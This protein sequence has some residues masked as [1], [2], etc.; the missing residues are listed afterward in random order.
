ME[1]ELNFDF[2]ETQV[3]VGSQA[4]NLAGDP[5]GR[6]DYLKTT[7]ISAVLTG[8]PSVGKAISDSIIRGPGVQYNRFAEWAK[9]SGYND[10]VGNNVGLLLSKPPL[11]AEAFDAIVPSSG[12]IEHRLLYEKIDSIN[13]SWLARQ[14][15]NDNYPDKFTDDYK[16]TYEMLD[17]V[18]TGDLIITFSDLTEVTFTPSI[19]V[20]DPANKQYLYIDYQ[21]RDLTPLTPP[22]TPDWTET[23]VEDDIPSTTGYT[24]GYVDDI[25][26]LEIDP[27]GEVAT[28]TEYL[29]IFPD[30]TDYSTM[31]PDETAYSSTTYS[32]NFNSKVGTFSK[33]TYPPSTENIGYIERDFTLH[34]EYL[35]RIDAVVTPVTTDTTVIK[36][37]LGVDYTVNK[38]VVTTTT[39]R[40]VVPTYR[41]RETY[42]DTQAAN[43]ESPK[44]AIYLMG[45]DVGIDTLIGSTEEI[46][47]DY[48]P[49]IPVRR[50]NVF[51]TEANYPDQYDWNKRAARHAFGKNILADLIENMSTSPQLSELDHAWI[52]FGVSLGTKQTEGKEYIYQFFKTLVGNSVGV[53]GVDYQLEW[54]A[55]IAA[56]D[57]YVV[58]RNN[59][60]ENS[61]NPPPVIPA[62][63]AAPIHT[64]GMRTESGNSNFWIY[65][66]TITAAGGGRTIGTGFHPSSEN[67]VGNTWIRLNGALV[68]EMPTVE[69]DFFINISI[70]YPSRSTDIISIGKQLTDN[71]WEEYEFWDMD[72]KSV[73]DGGHAI[74]TS[75]SEAVLTGGENFPFIIPM[76]DAIFKSMPLVSRNQLALESAFLV[77][78]FYKT[79]RVDWYNTE[80]FQFIILCLIMYFTWGYGLE[81]GIGLLGTNTA[82]GIALGASA[83][84]AVL[85][86]AIANAIAAAV[87][88]AAISKIAEELF[89]D[90]DLA[91][92]IA[93]VATVVVMMWGANGFKFD[94]AAITHSLTRADTLIQLSMSGLD[95]YNKYIARETAT[96]AG[97]TQVLMGDY[98]TKMKELADLTKAF[99]APTGVDTQQIVDALRYI[100]ESEK[101]FLNRT[102]MTG[103]D[104]VGITTK[105]V[106]QFP[107]QQLILPLELV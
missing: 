106:E 81:A 102:L 1:W 84:Y 88:A 55:Y 25:A 62:V 74:I 48:F 37:Y 6:T 23:E 34:V 75:G 100:P 10:T 85:V 27:Y 4:Y 61:L 2:D 73:V 89:G 29:P 97:E 46:L 26:L 60:D 86:G 7:V 91:K 24:G 58:A 32:Q 82:V 105:L 8:A 3:S 39:V 50:D 103:D 69:G 80:I 93:F 49:I 22:V 90:T 59:L 87:V 31:F 28:F 47:G 35:Y 14:Y 20:L 63:P 44:V 64:F 94:M 57:E 17:G 71:S 51:V 99:M 83:A 52:V 42:Q 18:Q 40:T 70:A 56:Y 72:H 21:S 11:S 12:S 95:T 38:R 107:A 41:H 36:N 13:L 101:Q 30:T 79:T 15:V 45:S 98:E 43:W 76:N 16:V 66:T 54:D 68:R 53:K 19:N 33:T 96:I 78:S 92:A 65:N 9:T 5:E 104:I 77:I 67:T